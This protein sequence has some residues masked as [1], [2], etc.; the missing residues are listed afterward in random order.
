[1]SR[2]PLIVVIDD[3]KPFIELMTDVLS[4]EGYTVVD[5]QSEAE[6]IPCIEQHKPDMV[7]LDI[8]VERLGGGWNVLQKMRQH[9]Q[10][11]D[12]PV[13]ICSADVTFLR[14]KANQLRS[15]KSDMLGKPFDLE[16]MLE[17]IKDALTL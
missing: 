4:E 7:I 2:A 13:I 12:I 10:V 9:P 6:A 11:K 1:M 14:E 17:K 15:K 3:D 8:H 5:C 16:E